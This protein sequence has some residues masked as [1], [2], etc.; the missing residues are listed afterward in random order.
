MRGPDG[1]IIT[2]RAAHFNKDAQGSEYSAWKG[3][4]LVILEHSD[5][6]LFWVHWTTLQLD[7]PL[8]PG[9]RVNFCGEVR[10]IRPMHTLVF[11][12][13]LLTC[14]TTC[15]SCSIIPALFEKPIQI[16]PL[17]RMR[18]RGPTSTRVI[19]YCLSKAARKLVNKSW[20]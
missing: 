15:L 18:M 19:P 1:E 10:D 4:I 3:S 17:C 13:M 12:N 16:H 20:I 7:P 2:T 9:A 5:S 11:T 8:N 6:F 14:T